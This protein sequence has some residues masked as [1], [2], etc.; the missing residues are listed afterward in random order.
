MNADQTRCTTVLPWA[1]KIVL[2][3]TRGVYVGP[4]SDTAPHAHHAIQICLAMDGHVRLR[5]SPC[6]PWRTFDGVVIASDTSHQLDAGGAHVALVYLEPETTDGRRIAP[7]TADGLCALDRETTAALRSRLSKTEAADAQAVDRMVVECFGLM[8]LE[9]H[10]VDRRV[11]RVVR[12]LGQ[13]PEEPASLSGSAALVGLSAERFRHLFMREV[14][15]PY[16]RFLVWLKLQA[17]LR[18]MSR[19]LTL[20]EAAH[21]AG[22][23]DSAHLSRSFRRMFGI[24]PSRASK[25]VQS[26]A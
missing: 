22:F 5:T 15:V 11:A 10:R 17:A 23:A 16:R 24:T 20:T 4:A 25:N 26:V 9:A 2:S 21:E 1:G 8:P 3:H 19:G 13:R 18:A 14:G 6:R 7:R 12:H